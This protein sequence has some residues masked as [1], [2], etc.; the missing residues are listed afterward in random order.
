MLSE[1]QTKSANYL[2][3]V[4]VLKT[5]KENGAITEK[6]YARAKRNTGNGGRTLFQP[7]EP[8]KKYVLSRFY[9]IFPFAL[10]ITVSLRIM[11]LTPGKEVTP[12][13]YH[14]PPNPEI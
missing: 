8:G 4:S 14:K 9:S 11:S 6:E 10:A 5:L 1:K 12:T 7:I 3:I 2:C 13:F